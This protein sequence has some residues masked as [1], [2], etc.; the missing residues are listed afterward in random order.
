MIF[1]SSQVTMHTPTHK[2]LN[3]GQKP[4]CKTNLMWENAI[5]MKFANSKATAEHT[6]KFHNEVIIS[7]ICMFSFLNST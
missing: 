2:E 3:Q 4:I 7:I 6:E 1:L 5:E